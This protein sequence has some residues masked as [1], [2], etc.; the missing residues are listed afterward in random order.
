MTKVPTGT[1]PVST[2]TPTSSATTI[3]LSTGTPV[4][5][6]HAKPPESSTRGTKRRL[7]SVCSAP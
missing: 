7:C 4:A 2:T 5:H 1:V 6:S 3:A